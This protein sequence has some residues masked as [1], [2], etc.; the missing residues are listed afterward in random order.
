MLRRRARAAVRRRPSRSSARSRGAV[1]AR[2]RHAEALPAIVSVPVRGLILLLAAALNA[3]V[4]LPLPLAPPVTVSQDVPSLTPVHAHPAGDATPVEPGP[5]AAGDRAAHRRDRIRAIDARPRH[6]ETL[7][8]NR[9]G[10]RARVGAALGRGAERHRAAA[11]A[12]RAPRDRQPG[13][14]VAH[15]CPRIPSRRRHTRRARAASCRH[16]AVVA[17]SRRVQAMPGCVTL[18][19]CPAIVRVPVREV[20]LLLAAALNAT[21]PLPLPLA[22][23]VTVSQDVLLLTPVHAHPASDVTP[24][25]PVPPAA[26]TQPFVG[27]IEY[28][29]VRPVCVTLK[30]CPATGERAPRARIDAAVGRRA[31]R[32]RAVAAPARATGNCQPRR[33]VAH[34]GPRTPGRRRH[35]RRSRCLQFAGTEPGPS[36][37]S[38]YAEAMPG[39]VTLKL[40]P[41]M[42]SVPVRELVLLLAAALNATVPL[43]LPL[44]PP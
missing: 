35:A 13:R 12:A 10:A 26:G 15:A 38:A 44:A 7:S 17:L 8:L 34:A 11:S 25:E 41:A 6:A 40:C 28:V 30:L 1:D 32:H 3:T 31:E 37:A 20:V 42:V 22:P 2:L 27:T 21:V 14:A 18:K 19:L 39:C 33:V 4:P 9:Q 16:R 5:P 23:P 43:P 29:H 36:P 24:V